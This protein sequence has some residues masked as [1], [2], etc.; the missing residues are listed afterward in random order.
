MARISAK[1]PQIPVPP[2]MQQ[3]IPPAPHGMSLQARPK[4]VPHPTIAG[5]DVHGRMLPGITPPGAAPPFQA[6]T[7]LKGKGKAAPV[8]PASIAALL[9]GPP[10]NAL[11]VPTPKKR[12]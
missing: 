7:K 9:A 3:A 10:S 5:R 2:V 1:A 4:R 6:A 12:K 11:P 8:G